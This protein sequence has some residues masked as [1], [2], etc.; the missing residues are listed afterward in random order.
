M[1][2]LYRTLEI[3]GILFAAFFLGYLLFLMVY[4]V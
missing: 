1:K 3:L 4:V 2:Y